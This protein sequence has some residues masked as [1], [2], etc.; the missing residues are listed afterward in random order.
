LVAA[1]LRRDPDSKLRNPALFLLSFVDSI[2]L[3]SFV[4]AFFNV[5]APFG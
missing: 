4:P 3:G 5:I 2:E 1:S